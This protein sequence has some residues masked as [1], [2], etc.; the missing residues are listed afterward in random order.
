MEGGREGF[1]WS[2]D[3]KYDIRNRINTRGGGRMGRLGRKD[4][5]GCVRGRNVM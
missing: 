4:R 1:W 5:P 3:V 2:K